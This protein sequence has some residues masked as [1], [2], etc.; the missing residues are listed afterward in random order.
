MFSV[1]WA[2][3]RDQQV[4]IDA[5]V[6]IFYSVGAGFGVHM[7][8]A[9]YNKFHNNC[10]RLVDT[11]FYNAMCWLFFRVQL[12]TYKRLHYYKLGLFFFNAEDCCMVVSQCG[13][14]NRLP[15]TAKTLQKIGLVQLLL[16]CRAP[17]NTGTF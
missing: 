10:Y 13:S 12:A 8:Y 5:A 1:D 6:Q 4:W 2:R 14:C 9:S 16:V 11:L 3:L 15:F 17:L 7:A